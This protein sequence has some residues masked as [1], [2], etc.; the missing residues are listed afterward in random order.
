M[1]ALGES[2]LLLVDAA[3][4]CGGAC[5]LAVLALR[6]ARRGTWRNPLGPL[7][8]PVGGPGFEHVLGVFVTYVALAF[9]LGLVLIRTGQLDPEAARLSGSHDWHLAQCVDVGARLA[10]SALVL[11]ILRRHRSFPAGDRRPTGR[12]GLLGV[13]CA[14]ALVIL[15]IAYLQLHTGQIIWRW[16]EPGA[17]QPIHAVLEAI[18]TSAWGLAGKAQLTLTA[19]M[20]APLAEELFFRGLLLQTF[21]RYLGQAWLAIALSGVAFGLIHNEQP[22]AVLPMMTMGVILGYVRVR[23]R[24]LTTCVLVHALFNA[25][26]MI[27]VLLA[28]EMAYSGG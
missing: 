2:T 24:S 16:L 1:L 11:A 26:T 12:P 19:I 9:S 18:E 25:R 3:L 15:P 13:G 4:H 6:W 27:Y 28:P 8:P 14:A 5:V 20:V 7:E 23:Y 17:E 22:Q 10:T 21:W